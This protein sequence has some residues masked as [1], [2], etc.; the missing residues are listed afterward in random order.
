MKRG[1]E[2][3]TLGEICDILDS[4]RKPIT[5]CDRVFGQ[6]PYY[7]ATGILDF[8]QDFIFSETLVLIGEDGAKW[9][10][11]DSSA[12]IA[13]GKYWVNNHAHVVRPK[14]GILFQKWLVY[15]LNHSDLSVFITGL[16]VPKLNQ[17]KLR[18]ISI[19]IPPLAEQDEIVAIL[20]EAFAA[21]DQA[22]ENL[23]KNIQNA[24]D[25]FQSELNA[26]FSQKGEG[27]VEKRLCDI[28]EFNPK[29]KEAR[30][31]LDDDDLVSFLPME[32][33]GKENEEIA[34]TKERFFKDVHASYTYFANG[35]VLLAKITP[36]FENGKIGI[37]DNL[38]NGI[39]FGSSEYIVFRSKQIVNAQL[40]LYFLSRKSFKEEG[41][42]L[43]TGAVG[44]KRVSK[45]WLENFEM[46]F[47][48][49]FIEQKNIIDRI[50]QISLNKGVLIQS[51]IKKSKFLDEL[52]KSILNKAFSGELTVSQVET[53]P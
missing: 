50:D 28:F 7:G 20:D 34:L 47:P 24:K 39:G 4:R 44:H 48:E 19:P 35:D 36:C 18:G 51:Y 46:P 49:S 2:L 12:F 45:D 13:E 1:W 37:A 40:L 52:K 31:L 32:D 30:D 6:Y 53:A 42:K 16:T 27:W 23:E 10:S 25:L 17:E 26:I 38:K 9:N 8:V 14:P 15:Y 11:G 3:L 43:M 5:K 41:A 22:K 33:L 29:K 21:I